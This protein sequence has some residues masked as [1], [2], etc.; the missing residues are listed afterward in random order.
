MKPATCGAFDALFVPEL[1]DVTQTDVTQT[2]LTQTD[3]TQNVKRLKRK[4]GWADQA[5]RKQEEGTVQ[6]GEISD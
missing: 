6:G 1:G 2:V 4:Q 3:V 5:G